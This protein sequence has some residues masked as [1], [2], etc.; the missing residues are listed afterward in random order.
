M[1]KAGI[2]IIDLVIVI[3]LIIAV[4]KG[5]E[6][7]FI[8]EFVKIL[9]ILIGLIVGTKYMSNVSH[10]IVEAT[11]IAPILA[12]VF[13]F[14]LIFVSMVYLFKYISG[15][16]KAATN[17]T[18]ALGGIDKIAGGILGLAKGA[19]IIS[20]IT[21]AL[22]FA[23]VFDYTKPIISESQLFEPMKEVAP[24]VYDAVKVFVP[25]SKSFVTEFKKNFSGVSINNM[26]N[27]TQ[28]FIQTLEE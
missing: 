6:R 13:S 18:V 7:G 15:K 8:E 16:I 5:Y 27:E 28:Q 4:Y 17:Y 3:S 1:I 26:T 22:S 24:T 25:N 21:I 2:S 14:I 9:G 23:N 11:K 20:L 19:I 10:Y 12:T